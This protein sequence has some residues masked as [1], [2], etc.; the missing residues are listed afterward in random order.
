MRTE[1]C[2]NGKPTDEVRNI[3]PIR[4]P[5][6]GPATRVIDSIGGR[7]CTG[8]GRQVVVV[9]IVDER[10]AKYE[11]RSSRLRKWA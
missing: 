7:V 8:S 5:A 3:E 11:E 9:A 4:E 2:E 10:V 6:G 1:T